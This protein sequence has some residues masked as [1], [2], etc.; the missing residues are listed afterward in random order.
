MDTTLVN[1]KYLF[2]APLK[3]DPVVFEFAPLAALTSMSDGSC[4]QSLPNPLLIR[5]IVDPKTHLG[6]G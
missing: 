6:R 1:Q 2:P 3:L 5:D 4:P